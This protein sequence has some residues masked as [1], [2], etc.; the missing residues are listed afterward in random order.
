MKILMALYEK[1]NMKWSSTYPPFSGREQDILLDFSHGP[2]LFHGYTILQTPGHTPD[3]VSLVD[4]KGNLF[5]G[6]AAANF[7]QFAGT[8]YTPPVIANLQE[9]YETWEKLLG[10]PIQRIYPGHG[11]SF[12]SGKLAQNLYSLKKA[13]D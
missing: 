8:K 3:S 4:D 13:I 2:V 10:L 1:F 6:D 9:F 11:K 12:A 7:H 5:C